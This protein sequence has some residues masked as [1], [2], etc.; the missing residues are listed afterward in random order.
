M[1]SDGVE[2]PIE[3]AARGAAEGATNA[4]LD[5]VNIKEWIKKFKE[6]DLAFIAKWQVVCAK[7]LFT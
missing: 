5:R 3:K 1:S 2:D 7:Y 4:I 6:K